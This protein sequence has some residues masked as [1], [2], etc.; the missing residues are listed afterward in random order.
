MG[1][2]RGSEVEAHKDS[3]VAAPLN[4]R[5]RYSAA[6]VPSEASPAV[7]ASPHLSPSSPG[8]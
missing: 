5:R 3:A 6:A 1:A 8:A 4:S 2:R 7:K